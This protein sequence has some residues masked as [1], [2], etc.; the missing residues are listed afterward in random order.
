MARRA[1]LRLSFLLALTLLAV[2]ALAA[3]APKTR[4]AEAPEIARVLS[5]LWTGIVERLPFLKAA[6][7][8]ASPDSGT[9]STEPDRSASLD[10]MG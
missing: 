1:L 8:T 5:R 2:P 10:P 4:P 7:D 9:G 3:G 6:A